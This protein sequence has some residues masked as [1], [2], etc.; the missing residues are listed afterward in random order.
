MLLLYSL[1]VNDKNKSLAEG[2]APGTSF[3][4]RADILLNF[5][6]SFLFFSYELVLFFYLSGVN[7]KSK[8]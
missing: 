8:S 7:D 2:V 3:P 4:K 5:Y 1:V 6:I